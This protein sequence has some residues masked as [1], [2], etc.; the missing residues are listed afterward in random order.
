MNIRQL[1]LDDFQ[2]GYL[3]LLSNL[4]QVGEGDFLKRFSE[5][6]KLYPYLQIWVIELE[7]RVIATGTVLIEP[8]F[9]HK[10]S[11]V[12]HIEDVVVSREYQG[13]GIGKM[14]IEQLTELCK[15]E[16][17]YKVILD[18]SENKKGFY[19]KCGFGNKNIQMS[20][21]F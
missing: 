4:T 2:K 12:G 14:L 21:Y 8:K 19:E 9:I 6:D 20:L 1:Q 17:C 13:R 7:D 15:K 16:G 11:Y 10:C 3:D 18:C 5:I